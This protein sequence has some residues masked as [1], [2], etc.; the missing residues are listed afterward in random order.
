MK[1]GRDLPLLEHHTSQKMVPGLSGTCQALSDGPKKEATI[2]RP[3]EISCMCDWALSSLLAAYLRAMK[4]MAP[5]QAATVFWTRCFCLRN[6]FK[7]RCRPTCR[8]QEQGLLSLCTR[9]L[10]LPMFLSPTRR[11]RP[12]WANSI[13]VIGKSV[14]EC[15]LCHYCHQ[16][17]RDLL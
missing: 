5:G 6:I 8:G 2:S 10:E 3:Q 13:L 16:I 9:I 12:S 4:K 7:D 14:G 17:L 15:R 1:R 11:R